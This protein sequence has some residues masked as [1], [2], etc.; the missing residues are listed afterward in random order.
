MAQE[1]AFKPLMQFA[2]PSGFSSGRTAA[3]DRCVQ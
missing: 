2:D 3:G 1:R